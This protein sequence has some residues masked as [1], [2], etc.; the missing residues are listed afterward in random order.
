M[1]DGLNQQL[2]AAAERRS[3]LEK[4]RRQVAELEREHGEAAA[5]ADRLGRALAKEER[6]VKRLEGLSLSSLV[7]SFFGRRDEQ[8]LKEQQEA[9]AAQLKYDEAR[10]RS[11]RLGAQLEAAR[12][13]MAALS[14]ADA[15]YSTLLAEKE[16]VMRQS[17]TRGSG[18]L[19]RLTEQEQQA[20]WRLKALQEARRAGIEADAALT[21]VESSLDSARGWGTF[22]MLGGGL[23]ATAAKHSRIDEAKGELYHAQEALARFRREVKELQVGMQVPTIELDGFSRFAD[24]FFDGLLADIAVQSQI[25]GSLSSVRRSRE[26]VGEAL[27]WVDQQMAEAER[28]LESARQERQ[29]FVEG[30][31]EG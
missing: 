20:A 26:R 29:R 5:Q 15:A 7:A 12:R 21:R 23:I 6:D 2:A 1:I 27:A 24:F 11:E 4:L 28:A 14:G 19:L 22:D 17:G 8:L 18:E 30:Y 31:R 10:I 3:R 25:N 16:R 9:V 13:E